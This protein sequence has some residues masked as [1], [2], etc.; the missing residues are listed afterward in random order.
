MSVQL[1]QSQDKST[2]VGKKYSK[3]KSAETCCTSIGKINPSANIGKETTPV[4]TVL[5]NQASLN[6]VQ[7]KSA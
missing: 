6:Y 3:T 7:N 2:Q 1:G 5:T 4:C